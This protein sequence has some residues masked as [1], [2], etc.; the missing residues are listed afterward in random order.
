MSR[1]NPAKAFAEQYAHTSCCVDDE[2][3]PLLHW[4]HFDEQM[5]ETLATMGLQVPEVMRFHVLAVADSHDRYEVYR[6]LDELS[7]SVSKFK[8]VHI[9]FSG[10]IPYIIDSAY[11][12]R[13]GVA[14]ISGALDTWL[15]DVY[16]ETETKIEVVSDVAA[17]SKSQTND[18]DD[19]SKFLCGKVVSDGK[20]HVYGT[21]LNGRDVLDYRMY[22]HPDPSRYSTLQSYGKEREI[23]GSIAPNL[24]Q[25]IVSEFRK[26]R[27]EFE[28]LYGDMYVKNQDSQANQTKDLVKS[29]IYVVNYRPLL[30]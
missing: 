13:N 6:V 16:D 24:A 7:S 14:S 25:R 19:A 1:N 26:K 22:A 27:G 15:M 30:E 5:F 2:S 17:P 10:G 28:M 12:N 3:I 18:D 29:D 8:K 9:S 11:A 21:F 23:T 20:E 4:P